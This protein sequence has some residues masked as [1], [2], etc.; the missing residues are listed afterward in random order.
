VTV[1]KR[2]VE[3]RPVLPQAIPR[4]C[5]RRMAFL[6]QSGLRKQA[7]KHKMEEKFGFYPYF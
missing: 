7:F 4:R 3:V 2:A 5:G 1:S 6:H